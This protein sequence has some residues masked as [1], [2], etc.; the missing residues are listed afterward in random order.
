MEGLM[1]IDG[2]KCFNCSGS[3]NITR[4]HL[5]GN[6]EGKIIPLCKKCHDKIDNVPY[7]KGMNFGIN[8]GKLMAVNKISRN[9]HGDG[10]GKLSINLKAWNKVKESLKL[11]PEEVKEDIENKKIA[12]DIPDGI[13]EYGKEKR[14]FK[15]YSSP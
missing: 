2:R 13:P 7:A 4:H 3:E 14:L 8:Q 5:M 9:L 1:K 11:F 10:N 6:G 12:E 15:H